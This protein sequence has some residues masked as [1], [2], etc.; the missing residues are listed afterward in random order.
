M[1]NILIIFLFLLISFFISLP[2]FAEKIFLS[3]E[4]KYYKMKYFNLNKT[5]YSASD[6]KN[7]PR[8]YHYMW[9]ELD[10]LN[11]TVNSSESSTKVKEDVLLVKDTYVYW[12]LDV[13]NFK[14]LYHLDRITGYLEISHHEKKSLDEQYRNYMCTKVQKIF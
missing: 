12:N 7:I 11:K 3:C 4:I 9:V 10:I 14:R 5:D 1:K 8:F 2:T 13:A 6:L